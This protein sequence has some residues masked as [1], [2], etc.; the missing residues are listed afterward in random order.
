MLIELDLNFNDAQALLRHCTE[1]QPIS[2]DAREDARLGDALETLAAAIED[3]M[4]SGRAS[5]ELQAIDPQLINAAIALFGNQATA[6]KWLSQP[7]KALGINAR[8]MC[9]SNTLSC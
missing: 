5:P 1:H 8:A 6:I 2:Q 9:H 7:L 4:N 3:A